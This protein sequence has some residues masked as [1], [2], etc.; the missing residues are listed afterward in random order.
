[1]ED[2]VEDYKYSD[3]FWQKSK[4]LYEYSDSKFKQF[5]SIAK[6]LKKISK[7]IFILVENLKT[8][9]Q[10]Y[11]K[12]KEINYTREVGINAFSLLLIL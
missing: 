3:C 4:I 6:I 1:M 2:Y 9:Y 7:N 10:L 12:P 8:I 5:L 11:E